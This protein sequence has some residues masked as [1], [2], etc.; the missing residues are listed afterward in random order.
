MKIGLLINIISVNKDLA[1]QSAFW[2]HA[3]G[4][5]KSITQ[6]GL[7]SNN[8]KFEVSFSP[9]RHQNTKFNFYKQFCF[10]SL[11]LGGHFSGLSGL[12][13]R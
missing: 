10:V 11:C 2:N 6:I 13:G 8:K 3:A 5:R 1:Q 7:T 12:G 9:P 4:R